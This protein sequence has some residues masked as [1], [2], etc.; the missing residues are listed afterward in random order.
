MEFGWSST[1]S[2]A[3]F[4]TAF[5]ALLLCWLP[6]FAGE[7]ASPKAD[8]TRISLKRLDSIKVKDFQATGVTPAAFALLLERKMKE[9]EPGGVG[10]RIVAVSSSQI[11]N[12]TEIRRISGSADNIS[13]KE[14]LTSICKANS[15]CWWCEKGQLMLSQE[16][17]R[18]D[19]PHEC[20]PNPEI[21]VGD[22]ELASR[23]ELTTFKHI[24]FEELSLD[25]ALARLTAVARDTAS[26][27]RPPAMLLKEWRFEVFN[28]STSKATITVSGDRMSYKESLDYVCK[29]SNT[30]WWLDG[31]IVF[32]GDMP[33]KAK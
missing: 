33:A 16:L 29:S 21:A 7:P 27:G 4:K 10:A 15:I 22:A 2:A 8:T 31:N 26:S 28:I 17:R 12:I 30:R 20:K 23:M 14:M 1:S 5:A 32:V 3:F 24:E 6:G 11:E 13:M 25:E 9:W 18:P 19:S